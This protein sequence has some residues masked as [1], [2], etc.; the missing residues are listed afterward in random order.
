MSLK[1]SKDVLK[2]VRFFNH[3]QD[4]GKEAKNVEHHNSRNYEHHGS[5]DYEQC[6]SKSV[7]FRDL[8]LG[9]YCTPQCTHL[10]THKDQVEELADDQ[11]DNYSIHC[12]KCLKLLHKEGNS[13]FF[14]CSDCKRKAPT[15]LTCLNSGVEPTKERTWGDKCI[16]CLMD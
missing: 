15:C 9:C 3:H 12:F 13:D 6:G 1:N 10:I 11:L 4:D 8:K 16:D 5:R 2:I 7:D 14:L